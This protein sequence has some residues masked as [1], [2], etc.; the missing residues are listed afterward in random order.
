MNH[1]LHGR[2]SHSRSPLHS[3]LALAVSSSLLLA[4]AAPAMAGEALD[5]WQQ[6]R[7]L[8]AAWAQPAVSAPAANRHRPLGIPGDV[9]SWRSDESAP[10]GP[11]AMGADHAYA[12]GLTGKGVRLALFDTGSALAHPRIRRP[13]HLQHHHRPELCVTGNRRRYRRVQ[14]DDRVINRVSTT[15]ALGAGLCLLPLQANIHCR[16]P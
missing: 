5:A 4:A 13:Q 2:S 10:T 8:Q 14:P 1:P 12:R 9:A 3:R 11:G 7:Q 15:T 6:Q 16:R